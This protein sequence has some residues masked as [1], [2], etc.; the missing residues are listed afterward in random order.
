MNATMELSLGLWQITLDWGDG[1]ET[2]LRF[3]TEQEALG[4]SERNGINVA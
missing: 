1:S 4:W 3:D 2:V